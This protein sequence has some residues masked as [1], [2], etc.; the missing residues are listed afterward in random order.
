M[1]KA[2][3]LKCHAPGGPGVETLPFRLAPIRRQA[4][5]IKPV[6]GVPSP[7]FGP[8]TRHDSPQGGTFQPGVEP[9]PERLQPAFLGKALGIEAAKLPQKRQDQ[10]LQF[11]T[12]AGLRQIKQ[13]LVPL[14]QQ[15]QGLLASGGRIPVGM[16]FWIAAV[17]EQSFEF[18]ITAGD[19]LGGQA[20]GGPISAKLLQAPAH[21]LLTF[22]DHPAIVKHKHGHRALGRSGQQFGWFGGQGHFP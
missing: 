16:T 1:D 18:A 6:R 12:L 15:G 22:I 14:P 4:E 8:G 3:L 9:G 19:Q 2:N 11:R 10:P 21:N 17:I 20:I 5:V 7:P 13:R